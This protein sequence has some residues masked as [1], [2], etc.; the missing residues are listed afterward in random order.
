MCLEGSWQRIP[1]LW[2][3]GGETDRLWLFL[4]AL[5]EKVHEDLYG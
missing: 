1:L 5:F 4:S 2:K 3:I